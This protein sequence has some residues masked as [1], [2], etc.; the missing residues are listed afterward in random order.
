[1]RACLPISKPLGGINRQTP[2]TGSREDCPK[3]LDAPAKKTR[4]ED[5]SAVGLLPQRNRTMGPLSWNLYS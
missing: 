3:G 2:L 1:M 4:P 5:K